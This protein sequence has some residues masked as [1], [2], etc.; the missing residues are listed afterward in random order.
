MFLKSGI[1]RRLLSIFFVVAVATILSFFILHMSPVDP[2]SLQLQRLGMP[3]NS[4][5]VAELRQ[6]F[7]LDEPILVQYIIW[8]KG[9]CMGDFGYSILFGVPVYDLLKEAIPKTVILAVSSLVLSVVITVPMALLAFFY[10]HRLPDLV[11]RFM[12]FAGISIPTFWLSLLLIYW[13]AVR[14]GWLPV[15]ARG[16]Q[17]LILPSAALAVW[18]SGLYI[19]RLRVS[20]LEE[21][22][23][24]YIIGAR[25]LG[26]SELT[27]LFKYLLPNALP[28]VVSM[29]GLTIGGLLG[30]SVVI[31][32]IFGWRGMGGA[33]G[34]SHV[35]SG[36]S[37]DAG[38]CPVGCGGL[39]FSKPCGRYHLPL[40]GSAAAEERGELMTL[41][42]LCGN[43]MLLLS[44]VLVIIWLFLAL[45]SPWIVPQDPF[46]VHMEERLQAGS[47]IHW[48]GTDSLGRDEFSRILYGSRVTLGIAFCGVG[49]TAAFGIMIGASIAFAGGKVEQV[50]TTILD[51]FL[52][53]PSRIFMIALIGVIG[54]SVW[55]VIIALVLTTWP[56]YARITRTLVRTEREKGYVRYAP[57]AGAGFY[58]IIFSYIL[59]NAVPQLL[60]FLCQHISEV[61][62]LVAGLSLIGIG[63]PPPSPEW[64]TLLM[65]AREYMQTA[66]W[67]LFYPGGAIFVTVV[68]FNLLGDAL[69]DALDPHD[70]AGE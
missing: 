57:Y 24:D 22:Q 47:M 23:K 45:I 13:F 40:F 6:K 48:M 42:K 59:P 17:G 51:F 25:T 49:L 16:W 53:F 52:A 37:S 30:G 46:A 11:I 33:D 20:I 43:K 36:L 29:L 5:L 68:I 62:L 18:M 44:L 9:V 50:G 60:V 56:E 38:I 54:A 58:H 4:E 66:P 2:V 1:G 35:E 65:G 14:L 26:L 8:L 31:E 34:G 63:V 61:I 32:T 70:M 3:P 12:T 15:I 41:R 28:G 19:R 55:G 67:L 64:G 69:R 21:Y 7:G 39:H 10:R 27:I